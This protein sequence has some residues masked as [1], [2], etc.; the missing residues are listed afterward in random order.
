MKPETTNGLRSILLKKK[1]WNAQDIF[2]ARKI[3]LLKPKTRDGCSDYGLCRLID[4]WIP[5]FSEV[6]E[7]HCDAHDDDYEIGDYSGKTR[8]EADMAF[9]RASLEVVKKL[10]STR[11]TRAALQLIR[12][13][14][15]VGVRMG[16]PRLFKK[17]YSWNYGLNL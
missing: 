9:F 12:G 14:Y 8:R 11:T 1:V 13:A 4:S 6:M 2:L 17:S 16:G 10:G 15:Y 7:P 3:G 5:G